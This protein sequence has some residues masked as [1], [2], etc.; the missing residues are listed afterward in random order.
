MPTNCT[1]RFGSVVTTYFPLR[2]LSLHMC[3]GFSAGNATVI[4]YQH[5]IARHND[6]GQIMIRGGTEPRKCMASVFD[7]VSNK[8]VGDSD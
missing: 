8:A 6:Y 7:T 4:S 2:T 3:A 1:V 5:R